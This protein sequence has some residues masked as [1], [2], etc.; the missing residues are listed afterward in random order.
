MDV[1][2]GVELHVGQGG[3]EWDVMC[4]GLVHKPAEGGEEGEG[5]W[6]RDSNDKAGSLNSTMISGGTWEGEDGI[7][8]EMRTYLVLGPSL[9]LVFMPRMRFFNSCRSA[10]T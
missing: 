8:M 1:A 9:A 2:T 5:F 6:W 3:L 4:L 10:D 7:S